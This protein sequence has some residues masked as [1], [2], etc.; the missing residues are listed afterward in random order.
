[1]A[2]KATTTDTK[3]AT[4][5]MART[6]SRPMITRMGIAQIRR[7]MGNLSSCSGSSTSKRAA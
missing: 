1:M 6:T 5:R 3:A 2:N 7:S 4:E